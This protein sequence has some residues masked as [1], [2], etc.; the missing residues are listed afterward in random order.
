MG[1][2]RWIYF[3]CAAGEAGHY[4]F[5]ER[6]RYASRANRNF[7]WADG[8][9]SPHPGEPLYL[10]AFSRL[11]GHGLSALSWWDRSQDKRPGSNSNVFAPS[12]TIS[13]QEMLDQLPLRFPWVISRL[14]QPLALYQPKVFIHDR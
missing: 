14:P 12:L 1:S 9:L 6:D 5:V 10:A 2:D 13:A 3:G 8:T 11:E 4:T 7:N